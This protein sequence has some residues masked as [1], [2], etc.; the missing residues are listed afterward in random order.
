M[1]HR[2]TFSTSTSSCTSLHKLGL[3]GHK[4]S[5]MDPEQYL[6]VIQ[7]ALDHGMRLLEA[8]QE[9]GDEALARALKTVKMPQEHVTVTTRLG[10]RTVLPDVDSHLT[11]RWD[12][13]VTVEKQTMNDDKE[14]EIVHNMS[15]PILDNLLSKCPLLQES[16]DFITVVPMIHNPEVQTNYEEDNPQDALYEKLLQCFRGMEEAVANSRISSYGVVSNGLSLPATHPLHL[17][18]KLVLKAAQDASGG[19]NV[20]NLRMM[21]LPANVMEPMGFQVAR[22]IRSHLANNQSWPLD[23]VCM[24]PLTWYPDQGTGTG[25]PVHLVD[26]VLPLEGE[27]MSTHQMEGPP[28]LYQAA[29]NRALSHFD[30]TELLEQK[31]QRA[32]TGEE[33]ETLEGCK[34]L[35]SI[36]HDLDVKLTSISSYAAFEEEL[37]KKV[38]PTLYGRFEALDEESSEVLQVRTDRYVVS[39]ALIFV[40]TAVRIPRISFGRTPKRCN[41][42]LQLVHAPCWKRVIRIGSRTRFLV[43]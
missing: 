33:R 12:G 11:R 23:I 6:Q 14:V 8:G 30:G 16:H 36:L 25:N 43:I 24:R 34:L 38:I 40:L 29:F 32:L 2:R 4:W 18:F 10:Y 42:P 15:P 21:Q 19:S 9:G 28:L 20:P 41:M 37:V 13:D 5:R 17:D 39:F 35:L 1:I 27:M 31:K 7:S 26:Y 22:N 3:G